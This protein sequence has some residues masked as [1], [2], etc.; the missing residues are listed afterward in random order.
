MQQPD[1]VIACQDAF[2]RDRVVRVYAGND[3]TVALGVPPG[4]W[5]ELTPRQLRQ[6]IAACRDRLRD[7]Q[8][9]A[10]AA[11]LKAVENDLLDG[12]PQ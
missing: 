1:A 12:V 8:F 2:G 10:I 7:A 3:R 9:A 11:D 4:E 5:V 6:L